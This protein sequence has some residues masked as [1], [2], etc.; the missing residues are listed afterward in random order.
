MKPLKLD[1]AGIR[2]RQDIARDNRCASGSQQDCQTDQGKTKC[3]LQ[4][5]VEALSPR[6]FQTTHRWPISP[7]GQPDNP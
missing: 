2:L 5:A 7:H 4:Q 3:R 6:K 1:L